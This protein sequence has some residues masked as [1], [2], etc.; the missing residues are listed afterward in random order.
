[1][2]FFVRDRGPAGVVVQCKGCGKDIP[3]GVEETPQTYIAV[4]CH[5]CE[6]SI[7]SRCDLLVCHRRGWH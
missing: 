3:A 5:A 7:A 4:R 1:M 6:T 2:A